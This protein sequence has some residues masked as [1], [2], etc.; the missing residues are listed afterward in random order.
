[1]YPGLLSVVVVICLSSLSAVLGQTPVTDVNRSRSQEFETL[2]REM[3]PHVG[4]KMTVVG[5]LTSGKLGWVVNFDKGFVYIYGSDMSEMNRL[6]RFAGR[7]VEV[8]GTLRYSPAPE[9]V[10]SPVAV[11]MVPEHFYFDLADV[12]VTSVPPP[13]VIDAEKAWPEFFASFRA[14]VR[15]RNRATLKK[16]MIPEFLYTLGHHTSDRRDEAF[17]YWDEPN[18]RGWK[19]LDRVLAQGAVK[20][21]ARWDPPGEEKRPRRIAPPAANVQRNLM[22]GKIDWYAEFVFRKD[23]KWYWV[24]FI[25]CCD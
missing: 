24:T 6:G 16:M 12:S 22:H 19:A 5:T 15:K 3:M 13:G 4:Q 9:P 25:Q 21:S 10:K 11:A 23:G 7:T 2:K 20:A 8:T 14:A 18:V 17:S 1:M